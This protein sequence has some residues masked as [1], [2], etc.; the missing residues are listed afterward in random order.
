MIIDVIKIAPKAPPAIERVCIRTL[1]TL[2]D[3]IEQNVISMDCN[4]FLTGLFHAVTWEMEMS[5]HCCQAMM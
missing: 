2:C 4:I 3:R 1:T 5:A